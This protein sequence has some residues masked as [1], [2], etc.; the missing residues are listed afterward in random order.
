MIVVRLLAYLGLVAMGLSLAM[1]LLTRDARYLRFTW[2]LLKF[3]LV[4]LLVLGALLLAGRAV[5]R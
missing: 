5:L 4:L 2:Q 3:S 1:F